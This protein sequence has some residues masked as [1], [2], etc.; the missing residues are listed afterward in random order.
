MKSLDKQT[1]YWD[2][3]AGEKT[4]THPLN[5]VVF[6]QLVP[7]E[8]TVI[9]IGCGY[10]RTCNAL[11]ELGYRN[12]LGLDISRRMVAH[13]RT[14]YPHLKLEALTPGTGSAHAESAD[15]VILFAVLTCIPT[16][17]GQTALMDKVAFI[18]KPGGIVYISD[19]WLQK[20]DRNLDRYGA[21]EDKYG[22]YGVFELPGGAVVRH[23]DRTWVQSLL[24]RFDALALE[25]ITV[26]TM[27]GHRSLGF[28]FFGRKKGGDLDAR[29]T[30]SRRQ[31]QF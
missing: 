19:Y 7:R 5:A 20:D 23:H 3:V 16:N 12:L 4:F 22:T 15:A 9:D 24:S 26:T 30:D 13:G 8:A 17:N 28:Q 21:F 2:S 25:D 18:L 29:Q 14:A 6:K 1:A 10:G 31:E 11:Y 27:N